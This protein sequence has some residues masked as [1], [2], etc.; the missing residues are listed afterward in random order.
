MC[1]PEGHRKEGASS[2]IYHGGGFDTNWSYLER[3]TLVERMPPADK[4]V[5]HFIL[6]PLAFLTGAEK[7]LSIHSESTGQATTG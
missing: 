3:G 7:E 2:V 6:F 5:G 4:S 1:W